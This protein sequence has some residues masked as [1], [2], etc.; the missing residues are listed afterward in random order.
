M[1]LKLS[2]SIF[3]HIKVVRKGIISLKKTRDISFILLVLLFI[4][5]IRS[6]VVSAETTV[7]S[8]KSNDIEVTGF[9][10]KNQELSL[11]HKGIWLKTQARNDG[12]F[13]FR[14]P[15]RAGDEALFLEN[16]EEDGIYR[17]RKAIVPQGIAQESPRFI[18]EIDSSWV[19]TSNLPGTKIMALVDGKYYSS[20]DELKIPIYEVD[21][22][23]PIITVHSDYYGSRSK[24]I[25][26]NPMQDVPVTF[27]I[28]E[29]KISENRLT[30]ST[31]PHTRVDIQ[32]SDGISLPHVQTIVSD[33][34]GH[35]D[36]QSDYPFYS[37]GG[38]S[39][40][41]F[42]LPLLNTRRKLPNSL[43]KTYD[44]TLPSITESHPVYLSNQF[45][46]EG[47]RIEGRT[48]NNADIKIQWDG[49]T[50]TCKA[51]S[52]NG[53]FSCEGIDSGKQ[54][55]LQI[56]LGG[57]VI[58]GTD[59]KVH[60]REEDY[61]APAIDW[62][63]LTSNSD[64][65]EG[66]I[67]VRFAKLRIT[68]SNKDGIFTMMTDSDEDGHFKIP[69]SR[70][71][72]G[73]IS[74][75]AAAKDGND[76]YMSYGVLKLKDERKLPRP[77]FVF[78]EEKPSR[79][80]L[81]Y[82]RVKD[83]QL[84][85]QVTVTHENGT[86]DYYEK[87]LH[88]YDDYSYELNDVINAGDRLS[89]R[90]IGDAGS[91]SEMIKT[92]IPSIKLDEL[93]DDVTRIDGSAQ[94]ADRIEMR[95]V[96]TTDDSNRKFVEADMEEDGTFSLD[97]SQLLIEGFSYPDLLKVYV[98]GGTVEKAIKY[99]DR[100]PP[101]LKIFSVA[102]SS[103][104]ISYYAYPHVLSK[105]DIN[106]IL[107]TIHYLDGRIEKQE[108]GIK[109]NPYYYPHPYYGS[110]QLNVDFSKVALI[111]ASA[112]DQTGNLSET[113]NIIPID[114]RLPS[115]AWVNPI[116]AGDTQIT[117]TALPHMK[118]SIDIGSS[119]YEGTSNDKGEFNIPCH[120]LQ[121]NERA[122][123]NVVNI[124][125]GVKNPSS[126]TRVVSGIIDFSLSQDRRSIK[127]ISNASTDRSFIIQYHQGN[128]SKRLTLTDKNYILALNQQLENH[129]IIKLSLVKD[130]KS[131][132]EFMKT[133][134]DTT[135]PSTPRKLNFTNKSG[136]Y[137]LEGVSE[138]YATITLSNGNKKIMS[139]KLNS[140]SSFKMQL[141]SDVVEDSKWRLTIS[142][143]VG[144]SFETSIVPK[145]V[146]PPS[147]K[148]LKEFSTLS[149]EVTGL[150]N[151]AATIYVSVKG[152]TYKKLTNPNITFHLPIA[153]LQKG[154]SI[155]VYAVD[156]SGNKSK[157]VLFK[158]LGIQKLTS[159]TVTSQSNLI[160]G[161]GTIG[162]AIT[163]KKGNV[164]IGRSTVDKKGNYSVKIA[165]QKKGIT[166]SIGSKKN[167]YVE[168]VIKVTIRK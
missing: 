163:I 115:S 23:T 61:L 113:I 121:A 13:T 39:K 112:T 166:L 78:S 9:A 71:A 152:K 119:H 42:S 88:E 38:T 87:M 105:F 165:K 114:D 151:E 52:E 11:L 81:R 5:S 4:I 1:I 158:V 32:Y 65:I 95:V 126:V 62:T 89:I 140:S 41:K 29:S 73:S 85:A 51:N 91:S 30:G 33:Y 134:S 145:D 66:R 59:F 103:K 50:R 31:L 146:Q 97:F 116:L 96:H 72:N 3:H 124:E 155:S 24:T 40:I 16:E 139:Q 37:R 27:E 64:W 35:F 58:H 77:S 111:E 108:F 161:T 25:D 12:S 46:V 122:E 34:A 135:A 130:E 167:G 84:Q 157:P 14:L 18:G 7:S 143:L 49:K 44:F 6:E 20:T 129:G 159:M 144:N 60:Q 168:K 138:P 86:F 127:I 162:A 94:D 67:V 8:L 74:V 56:S 19:F 54:G 75:E 55:N 117:G 45:I 17:Q 149:K 43:L 53:L 102:F 83:S 79:F 120:V 107:Y 28:E 137:V 123:I 47:T 142:D 48:F 63:P 110:N 80:F 76:V 154:A 101:K 99:E 133:F 160:R 164:I 98:N 148:I 2:A 118:V 10:E 132:G 131:Q 26:V 141:P 82:E 22:A 128:I 69:F 125:T 109:I 57:K 36:V 92:I 93:R 156:K 90:V 153:P 15:S 136:L 100:T 104:N 68:Y 21:S 106:K 147:L 150:T 70:K